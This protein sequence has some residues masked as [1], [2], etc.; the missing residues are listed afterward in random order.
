M[1]AMYSLPMSVS[2]AT[3]SIVAPALNLSPLHAAA[4]HA[5]EALK[6]ADALLITAGAGIGVDSGLPDFRGDHGFWEAYPALGKAKIAFT[7]VASP[8]TFRTDPTLAWGFYGHRLNL[9]RK[10]IPHAGFHL[11][12]EWGE[13]LEHGA[14][15]YTSNVDGQFQKAGFDAKRIV[16]C[17][18]SIHHLQCLDACNTRIESAD[19]FE[20]EIDQD[21]CRILSKLP[22]CPDCGALMRPNILMFGDWE[23]MQDR[24]AEQQQRM[25]QWLRKPKRLVIVEMGAG[26]AIATVRR[27]GER[28]LD[29]HKQLTPTLIRINPTEADG[30]D[31]TISLKAGALAG[32]TAINERLK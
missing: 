21:A 18:G 8:H 7:D 3:E 17:H 27:L 6:Q 14:Q 28:I 20:P 22:H 2:V 9:Y 23:W 4:Q 10:T 5:A 32:L 15:I 16:E 31:G 25:N 11:L 24:Y 1:H 13:Q 12:R 29:Q 19:W 26:T 30:P